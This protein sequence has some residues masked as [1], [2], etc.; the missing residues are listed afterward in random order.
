[1]CP[2]YKKKDKM[3]IENYCPIT[4]LNTD[5]KLLTKALALQLIHSIKCMVHPDQV[6]FIPGRTIFNHIRLTKIMIKYAEAM[7]TNGA[8]IA[9][10]Q[11]KAYDKI[12]H[13]YLWKTLEAFW[14]PAPFR[15]TIR[16]LYE[17]ASTTVVI[18]GEFSSRYQVKCR[19]HQ[20]DPLSCFLFTLAI[21]PLAALIRNNPEIKGF[22]IPGLAKKLAINLFT[23][24][25]VIYANKWDNFGEIQHMLDLWCKVAGAKFNWEKTEIIP[26]GTKVYCESVINMWRLNPED[27]PLDESIHI[28][29][30]GKTICSLGAWIGNNAEEDLA[31]EPI[32]DKIRDSLKHWGRIH[33]MLDGKK[34]IM[35]A[36]VGGYMQFLTKAQGM[37]QNIQE[38]ITKEINTFIWGEDKKAPIA[39]ETLHTKR[40]NGRIGLLDIQSRNKAID[41][42]WLK[43]YISK[44]SVWL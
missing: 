18:N 4:L 15:N 41:V 26:I 42:M 23:D 39:K 31:W 27:T 7:E 13:H 21:E 16:F 8:I 10:D 36:I 40:Q 35:Q 25:M 29:H 38:A 5:Y 22:N 28:A 17:H 9:L 20:G 44:S 24:D 3:K 30:D 2:I 43:E 12:N 19:V 14:I 37:P 33:P 34:T 6:G 1:M 11:E 32:V